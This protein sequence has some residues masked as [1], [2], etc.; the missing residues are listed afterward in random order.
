MPKLPAV[1][2][3]SPFSWHHD[4]R[5]ESVIVQAIFVRVQ[6]LSLVGH[7]QL[8]FYSFTLV[9]LLKTFGLKPE[10]SNFLRFISMHAKFYKEPEGICLFFA[11]L[12]MSP[13]L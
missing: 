11:H 13:L 9:Y 12:E 5:I 2:N 7:I 3:F 6:F 1:L 4:G 10:G 8:G